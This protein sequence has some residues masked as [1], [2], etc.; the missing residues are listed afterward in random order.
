MVDTNVAAEDIIWSVKDCQ[1]KSSA[2]QQ[3][4]D[5]H[6]EHRLPTYH[7]LPVRREN[8][9]SLS[10]VPCVRHDIYIEGDANLD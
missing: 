7:S 2:F 3:R 6:R 10:T 4:G 9:G 8:V 5:Y 1:A